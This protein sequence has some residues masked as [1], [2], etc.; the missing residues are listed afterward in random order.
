[1]KNK[2]LLLAL[3][4]IGFG[5]LNAQ[6]WPVRYDA[7]VLPPAASPAWTIKDGSPGPFGEIVDGKFLKLNAIP[8]AAKQTW[9]L[10]Q[11][12]I[13]AAVGATAVFGVKASPELI[14]AIQG[15]PTSDYRI[16]E[17]EIRTGT[18]RE[19]IWI[20]GRDSVFLGKSAIKGG[21]PSGKS[22]KDFHIYRVTLKDSVVNVYVD[23][24]STPIM[25]GNIPSSATDKAQEFRI[26]NQA[27]VGSVGY[28]QMLSFLVGDVT[29]A[30]S[31]TQKVLPADLLAQI[32]TAVNDVQA[33]VSG[34]KLNQN[35]PNPFNPS[36]QIS[37]NLDK[38]ANT[39]LSVY[40][41]LGQKV[42]TLFNGNLN[43]GAH[44]FTF[45][46][47]NLESGIYVYQLKSGNFTET[48]KMMLLK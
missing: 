3:I 10:T 25:T 13:S 42:A 20:L 47:A 8:V 16:F 23:E 44:A 35:Y 41:M 26:G 40:N 18:L 22:T 46:A 43:S 6:T 38:A 28:G 45:N 14:T 7:T 34:Y 32:P 17:L 48:R 37:F 21:L 5:S 11:S 29:G 33:K 27:S 1:M 31:P 12:S 4:A 39:N 19:Q 30:Y 15:A 24:N 2:L 36:T 9:L